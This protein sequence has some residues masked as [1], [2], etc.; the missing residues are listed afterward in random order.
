[1]GRKTFESIGRPLPNRINY[2]ISRTVKKIDGAYVFDNLEDA[3]LAAEKHNGEMGI[4][5]EIVIIGGGYLF[6]ETLPVMNKL[7][8]TKVDCN[9]LGDIYY[10]KVEMEK[11]KLVN[12]ESYTKNLDNDYDFKIEEYIKL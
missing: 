7:V 3:M 1:M 11:F 5:N 12:S 8:I 6:K 2:V 9:V 10:P 4:I